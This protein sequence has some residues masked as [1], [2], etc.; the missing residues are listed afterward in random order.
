[1]LKIIFGKFENM[2]VRIYPVRV[3]GDRACREIV[4]GIEYFN[5]SAT[6]T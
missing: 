3:Q 4:E 2:A 5:A 1:M 6:S